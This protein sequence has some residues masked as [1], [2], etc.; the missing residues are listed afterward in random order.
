MKYDSFLQKVTVKWKLVIFIKQL[1]T[2]IRMLF[3]IK[4]ATKITAETAEEI[5]SFSPKILAATSMFTQQNASLAILKQA[6]ERV[7][8]LKTIMGSPN[9]SG[10]AG[11]AL[12]KY[13]PQVDVVCFGEGDDVI[14]DAVNALIEDTPM[15]YGV[16][17]TG[18]VTAGKRSATASA[19]W[20][21]SK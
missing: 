12:L 15:P 9:C 3:C 4:A 5:A 2:D 11:L 20:L 14:V 7:P 8:G 1:K 13:F 10:R 19:V 17:R 18:D 6:K 16:L 21:G